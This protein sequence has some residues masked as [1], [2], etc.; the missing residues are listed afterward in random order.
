RRR[1]TRSVKAMTRRGWKCLGPGHLDAWATSRRG[2]MRGLSRARHN[3]APWRLAQGVTF[4][5]FASLVPPR[6]VPG[7]RRPVLIEIHR[8]GAEALACLLLFGRADVRTSEEQPLQVRKGSV[9]QQFLPGVRAEGA[10]LQLQGFELLGEGGAPER[11]NL[12][13]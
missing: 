9:G 10:V 6:M 1:P 4:S 5:G 11:A 3:T 2:Q 13:A 8:L 7:P 12:G